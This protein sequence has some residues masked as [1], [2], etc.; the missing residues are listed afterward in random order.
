MGASK[1]APSYLLLSAFGFFTG[2]YLPDCDDEKQ[3]KQTGKSQPQ[4][5]SLFM[6]AI[7]GST[8]YTWFIWVGGGALK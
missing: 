7:V 4:P 6:R 5:W 8:V 1:Q 3:P 2:E